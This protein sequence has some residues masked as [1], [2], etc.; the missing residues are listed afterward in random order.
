MTPPDNTS[1][2]LPGWEKR[3]RR[4]ASQ[5][6]ETS[7]D[8]P[9]PRSP[10]YYA[11]QIT[12]ITTPEQARDLVELASQRPLSHIGFDCEYG[13]SRPPVALSGKQTRQDVRSIQPLLLSLAL[14]EPQSQEKGIVYP[15]V[16]DLRAP[17]LSS[18]LGEL[19]RLS[20]CFV[21]HAIRGDLFCLL[22]L[23][24]PEPRIFWDTQIHEMALYLGEQH[25]KYHLTGR[26][27]EVKDIQIQKEVQEKRQLSYSLLATCHRYGVPFIDPESKG[28]LQA[29]F[30]D[31]DP[32]APFT[33]EQIRYAAEDAIA[34]AHLYLPQ[35]LCAAK[36]GLLHHL[37][38]VEMPWVITSAHMEWV[39]V[40]VDQSRQQQVIR[41]C[42]R[43]QSTLAATLEGYGIRNTRSHKQLKAFF[44]RE[45]LIHLF[46][47]GNKVSFKK[48]RL[49]RLEN[50]HSVIPPLLAS[51]RVNDIL[52]GKVIDT[53]LVGADGRVHPSYR[54][55]GTDTSRETSR[56][57]N[58]QGLDSALRPLIVPARGYGIG[59]VDLC[60]IEIGIAAAIYR[61]E[62]LVEMFNS[63]DVYS[64]MAQVFYSEELPD[65]AR[66]LSGSEFKRRYRNQRST[67]KSCTL[68]IIYG[69]TAHGLSNMLHI[70][71]W[72]A[73]HLLARF[74]E[75]FPT[76]HHNLERVALLGGIRGY[77]STITGL[78]R[79]RPTA[80][81]QLSNWERNWLGNFPIQG[82]AA[83]VFKV[84]GN[85]LNQLYRSYDAQLIIPLHDAF[86]FEAPLSYLEEVADLT[87]RVM[88]EAVREFFPELQP[89]VEI[90]IKHPECWN[91]E[92][93]VKAL[94]RWLK[95]PLAKAGHRSTLEEEGSLDKEATS[96]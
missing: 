86:V 85:R 3:L 47:K 79:R 1:K 89:R 56:T 45:R 15:F 64:A 53:R 36:T 95:D 32:E 96:S 22:R 54:Q 44:E 57:P 88:C 72:K 37:M 61:D 92:G 91:K 18:I 25:K 74:K 43:H 77:A 76:V 66:S 39:G 58:I 24:L 10:Q 26:E 63:G 87:G 83:A 78:H 30:L 69:V 41:A 60:Q 81:R 23:G 13:F 73:Q 70:S 67:M 46:R 35:V 93:D 5:R 9:L 65:T 17:E 11:R 19:F 4:R 33:N 14:V 6:V 34:V 7:F 84:A 31:H 52:S 90:N 12:Q 29:S 51:R 82:S 71:Q 48:D 21:G 40:R 59:D 16:M 68:G 50:V 49:K 75:M 80:R 8:V 55:L 42:E 38:T 27:D 28:H 62:R 20:T 94:D 2:L